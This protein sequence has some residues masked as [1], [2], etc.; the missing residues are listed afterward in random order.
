MKENKM[1]PPNYKY[2]LR[3]KSLDDWNKQFTSR[4]GDGTGDIEEIYL[5]AMKIIATCKPGAKYLDIGCGFGRFVET[6]RHEAGMLVGLEPDFERFRYCYNQFNDGERVRIINSTSLEY[7]AKFPTD[8][9]DII[10]VSM[11]LQHIS[12]DQCDQILRDVRDILTT[13]GLAIISTTHFF[14][15]R[16]LYGYNQIP[17]SV[18]EFNKYALDTDN[19]KWGIPVRMFSK[20]SF[21]KS[22]SEADLEIIHWC[23]FSYIRPES[24]FQYADMRN[25]SV[26]AIQNVGISQYALVKP[27][28][29][30]D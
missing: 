17:Q 1:S 10:I 3:E 6:V 11:V 30:C 2:N 15:E 23:E 20:E 16:F 18:D 27:R 5:S 28:A 25:A 19:Q 13:Q 7:K 21:L 9:F 24:L 14:E 26:E 29:I 8:R 12:T 4:V 22:I